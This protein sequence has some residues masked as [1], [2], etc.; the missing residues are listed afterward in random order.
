MIGERFGQGAIITQALQQ[1]VK[2]AYGQLNALKQ[3][4]ESFQ[5]GS[6]GNSENADLGL[7]NFKPNGQKTKSFLQRLE[8]GTNIQS[9]KAKFMFPVTSDIGISI[10]Y[11][12]NDKSIVGVGASYKIGWGTGFNN[13]N[14]THQGLGIRSFLDYKVKGS[15]FVSGGYEQNY[16]N[17]FNSIE[18]LRNYSSWQSSGLIGLSKKYKV[19]KKIKGSFQMMW[20]FLSYQQIPQTEP[21][22]FRVAY[23][24]K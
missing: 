10:G 12:L 17:L 8:L 11:K 18:Q 9:Q 22:I 24:L 6:L 7:P 3:K 14:I 23:N 13:I 4:A 5:N 15:L 1:N 21:I 2:D 20:D 16:R 19:S